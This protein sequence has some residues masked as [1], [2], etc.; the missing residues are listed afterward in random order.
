MS[1]KTHLNA[2]DVAKIHN[3]FENGST[4]NKLILGSKYFMAGAFMKM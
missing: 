2:S 4:S 1:T 3:F